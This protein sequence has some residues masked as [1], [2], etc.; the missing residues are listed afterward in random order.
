M[1]VKPIPKGYH[2]ATPYLIVDNGR[3]ALE[4]YRKAFKASELSR[5]EDPA[6]GRI[7]H[8]E[9]KIGDSIIS[10]SMIGAALMAITGAI[11]L[12]ARYK[13]IKLQ[14]AEGWEEEYQLSTQPKVVEVEE[15]SDENEMEAEVEP[16]IAKPKATKAKAKPSTSKKTAA[17]SN[18]SRTAT[19]PKTTR[20]KKS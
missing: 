12:L 9:I 3:K 17:G 5:F 20:A 11:I 14:A 19:K 2:T 15:V 7:G 16:K 8:A 1:A 6:T 18:G 4:F 13:A 10:Y